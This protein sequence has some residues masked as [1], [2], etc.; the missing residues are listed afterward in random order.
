MKQHS[1]F[2]SALLLTITLFCSGSLFAQWSS[3]SS[4]L[5]TTNTNLRVGIGT[6][7]PTNAK[8]QFDNGLGNKITLFQRST[9]EAYGLGMNNDNLSAYIPSGARF[10][11]RNNS[12]SGAE[13][14]VVTYNGNVGVGTSAPIYA[15]DVRG[16]ISNGA[17]DFILGK[18]DGRAQGSKQLNRALVHYK[19]N[20]QIDDAL[21]INYEGDFEGGTVVDGPSLSAK[22][23]I[24]VGYSNTNNGTYDL[25]FGG[26]STGEGIGSKRTAGGN[27]GGLDFYTN[28]TS[29]MSIT[30]AGNVGIGINAPTTKLHVNGDVRCF[31]IFT[32]S[33]RRYKAN[34]QTLGGAMDKVMAMRGTSYD[35]AANQLPEGYTAGK[36]V[37][38]IAQEMKAV[39]P[40]LVKEDA[41][42][43]MSINY[44]GVI[45]V[46][47]EALKEQHEVIEEKETRIAALEAQNSELQTRLAR[48]EA[49]LGIAADRQTEVKTAPVSTKVSPNPT[50]GLVTIDLQNTSTAKS[51]VV[52]IVDAAGRQVATRNAAGTSSLQF[53]LSQLPSGVYVAQVI[54]DGK[55]VSNNKVQLV[56]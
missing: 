28:Y 50:S 32:N 25:R 11:V 24:H 33:D 38:F 27:Q 19:W 35:F 12:S 18:Y 6:S 14:F 54:A 55:M 21:V 1:F 31:N 34:I 40:E 37:G 30:T 13:K 16:N 36:Q 20:N 43:M 39:M 4:A 29:R 17:A 56:K 49:T 2:A 52:N 22:N 44:I 3:T 47:V 45:P 10:S 23:L 26:A 8:L 15:M 46:L 51:V 48:I 53:D 7:N 5:W 9:T 41:E 42:G